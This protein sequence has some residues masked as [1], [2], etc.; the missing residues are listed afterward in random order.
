MWTNKNISRIID[1][2]EIGLGWLSAITEWSTPRT[3]FH[4]PHSHEHLEL[5]FCMKGCLVY[6][7]EG[8]GTVTMNSGTGL[9]IPPDTTHVL[10]GEMDSPGERI[11]FHI[12]R[13]SNLRR[14]YGVFTSE[15]LSDFHE[16]M[17]KSAVRPFHLGASILSSIKEL[18]QIVRKPNLSPPELGLLRSLCCTIL[19][20][21][22]DAIIH[23][24]TPPKQHMMDEAIRFLEANYSKKIDADDLI[25]HM[26]YGRTQLYTLFKKHTGL[27]PNEYLV[28]FR[29]A[30]AQELL[31][32]RTPIEDVAS[33]V[34]FSSLRYFKQVFLKYTGQDPSTSDNH[35]NASHN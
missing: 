20:R 25:R 18:V 28:R 8:Y 19:Y 27:T 30:T 23:P 3:V 31:N 35:L 32:Q 14:R 34:G 15:T 4:N 13:S 7:V 6:E 1:R 10:K 22:V 26:G 5:I 16:A 24:V 29:I 12:A 33:A 9:V 21:A 2:K 17:L 11:G